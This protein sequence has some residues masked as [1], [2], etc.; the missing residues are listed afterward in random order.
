VE[1]ASDGATA[2]R[3]HAVVEDV[4][5]IQL[6]FGGALEEQPLLTST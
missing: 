4:A 2:T 6:R 3:A 1:V 5:H